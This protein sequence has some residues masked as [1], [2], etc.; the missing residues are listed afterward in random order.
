MIVS[1]RCSLEAPKA[2]AAAGPRPYPM[3]ELPRLNGANV[4]KE[5]QPISELMCTGPISFSSN[6]TAVNSG[7]SG[8]PV[9]RPGGRGGT[10][11]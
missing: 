10:A 3:I 4:E 8:H 7:R 5:W 2:D 6:F 9:H 11:C 1:A